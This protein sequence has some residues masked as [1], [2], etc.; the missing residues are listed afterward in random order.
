MRK[1]VVKSAKE[2]VRLQRTRSELYGKIQ[3]V[4]IEMDAAPTVSIVGVSLY[5]QACSKLMQHKF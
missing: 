5:M 2:C 1:R 4:F 3:A